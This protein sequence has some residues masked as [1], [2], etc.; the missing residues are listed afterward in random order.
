MTDG[1]LTS[2][3]SLGPRPRNR[4]GDRYVARLGPPRTGLGFGRRVRNGIRDEASGLGETPC[5]TCG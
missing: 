2:V 3:H 5:L 4:F 1:Y